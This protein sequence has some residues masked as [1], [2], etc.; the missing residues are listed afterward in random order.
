M[1]TVA[2][3]VRH[4]RENGALAL[5]DFDAVVD[6]VGLWTHD[7]GEATFKTASLAKAA[8]LLEAATPGADVATKALKHVGKYVLGEGETQTVFDS[9]DQAVASG[10]LSPD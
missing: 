10:R 1:T 5:I 8:E 9:F 6:G 7:G 3:A 2:E 4:I